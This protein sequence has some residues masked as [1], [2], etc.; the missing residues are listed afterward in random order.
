MSQADLHRFVTV[1]KNQPELAASYAGITSVDD[2]GAR[3]RAEGY[4]V[5]N[6][7]LAAARNAGAELSDAELDAVSGGLILEG[8]LVGGLLIGAVVGG[9]TMGVLMGTDG[10]KAKP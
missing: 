10:S 9:V 3:L 2:L 6:D 8:L 4:E 1:L 5:G 7:E